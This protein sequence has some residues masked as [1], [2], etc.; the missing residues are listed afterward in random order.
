V[1]KSPYKKQ[2]DKHIHAQQFTL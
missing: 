1:L 2:T